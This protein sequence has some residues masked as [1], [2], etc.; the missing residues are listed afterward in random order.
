M[1]IYIT[2]DIHTNTWVCTLEFV[3]RSNYGSNSN[4]CRNTTEIKYI[5]EKR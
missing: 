5:D 3:F 2:Q 1:N 4:M